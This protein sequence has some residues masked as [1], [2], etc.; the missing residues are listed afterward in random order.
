[1]AKYNMVDLVQQYSL[2]LIKRQRRDKLGVVK[3]RDHVS[4]NCDGHCL[5]I[6]TR[7]DNKP[8]QDVSME[9]MRIRDAQDGDRDFPFSD[10][11]L[12]KVP[13][14]VSMPSALS[15]FSGTY[16]RGLRRI[17]SQSP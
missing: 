17:R 3:Q 7:A 16:I 1:M 13:D 11:D 2:Q 14:C 12:A 5:D 10:L 6:G 8:F 15:C 4:L 9:G